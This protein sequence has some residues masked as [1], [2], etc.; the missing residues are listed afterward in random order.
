LGAG[1]P[2]NSPQPE[3]GKPNATAVGVPAAGTPAAPSTP[4]TAK[5]KTRT[6]W[7]PMPVHTY[8]IGASLY[9]VD[10]HDFVAEVGADATAGKKKDA[11]EGF[12]ERLRRLLPNARC[13]GWDWSRDKRPPPVTAP[14]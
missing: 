4:T 9:S 1:P 14:E 2:P 5:R 11:R 8:G 13:V 10:Q 6:T 3:S 12:L 7:E